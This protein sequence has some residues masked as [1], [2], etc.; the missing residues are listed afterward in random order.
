MKKRILDFIDR[1]HIKILYSTAAFAAAASIF[2]YRGTPVHVELKDKTGDGKQ[3]ITV[4]TRAGHQYI[5]LPQEDG[6][7][8]FINK[9]KEQELKQAEESI[10][11]KYEGL[12]EKIKQYK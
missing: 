1:H 4:N 11:E 2:T 5:F 12:E 6:T 9:A 8:L 10:K 3:E 7:Y